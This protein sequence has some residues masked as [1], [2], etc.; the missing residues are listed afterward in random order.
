MLKGGGTE[1]EFSEP[2][3][4]KAE[5]YH[6]SGRWTEFLQSPKGFPNCGGQH[7]GGS[8]W[9]EPSQTTLQDGHTGLTQ[10]VG[11]PL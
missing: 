7:G 11:A 4:E 9:W 10:L 6:R 3:S 2:D 8:G 1:N 5:N